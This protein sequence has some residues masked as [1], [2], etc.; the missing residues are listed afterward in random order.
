MRI[1][2]NEH[3]AKVGISNGKLVVTKNDVKLKTL[4][5]ELAESL[6]VSSSVQITSQALIFLSSHNVSVSW[7]SDQGKI[8]C[9]LLNNDECLAARRKKQYALSESRR[10]CN[11]FAKKIVYAKIRSQILLLSRL[12]ENTCFPEVDKAISMLSSAEKKCS[13]GSIAALRGIEGS[14]SRMYFSALS[15]FIDKQFGF[16]GRNRRPPRDCANAALSYGYSVLYNSVDVIL[17][18]HGFDTFVGFI[19]TPQSGHRALSSDMI[20]IFRPLV[21]DQAVLDFLRSANA[22]SDF[23]RN[24]KAVY[25]ADNGRKRLISCFERAI[26]SAAAAPD[27]YEQSCRGLMLYHADMLASAVDNKD[28][29][30]FD[31]YIEGENN[32]CS[33]DI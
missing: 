4:P 23:T 21:A 24:G 19:H 28:V 29:S 12:N 10:F 22:G 1:Y 20:E 7:I 31:P 6:L 2:I 14:A 11:A 32:A 33:G 27:G 9:S 30:R 26:S 15:F 17:R 18:N 16:S 25:L 5:A 13:S 8:V 3:G